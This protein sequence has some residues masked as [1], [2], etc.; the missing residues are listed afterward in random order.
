MST[1]PDA[2]TRFEWMLEAIR[3]ALQ[4]QLSQSSLERIERFKNARKKSNSRYRRLV[5]SL[6][7]SLHVHSPA[8][9]CDESP[10]QSIALTSSL[11]LMAH[12]DNAGINELIRRPTKQVF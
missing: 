1:I 11:M 5:Y 3:L 9:H 10:H 12:P 6:I 7:L 2:T 8:G 4:D